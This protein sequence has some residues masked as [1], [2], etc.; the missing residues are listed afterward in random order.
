M[1]EKERVIKA[2]PRLT[3]DQINE[4]FSIFREEKEK[5]SELEN[6]FKTHLLWNT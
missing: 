3:M 5:F 4:L 2:I 6:E 1:E